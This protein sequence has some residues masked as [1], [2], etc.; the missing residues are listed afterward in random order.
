[1]YIFAPMVADFCNMPQVFGECNSKYFGGELPLPDFDLLRSSNTCGYF[2]Y[3]TGGWFDHNVY[4]PVISMTDYYDFTESQFTDIMC[5]EMIHYYLALNGEDRKCRHG[6]AFQ[7]MA[8]ELN[9]N[10]G[11]NITKRLDLSQYR[12]NPNR[13]KRKGKVVRTNNN[14]QQNMRFFEEWNGFIWEYNSIGEY[15]SMLLGRLIGAILGVI[16]LVFL[17]CLGYYYTKGYWPDLT[18]IWELVKSLFS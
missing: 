15:L 6:R 12:K 14:P 2:H 16:I 5:H 9:M 11:L 4:D 13:G 1:M 18:P 3:N 17:V 10:Y 7:Q 8:D